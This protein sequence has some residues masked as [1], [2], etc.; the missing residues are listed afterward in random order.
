MNT[1]HSIH[2]VCEH[3]WT[4]N[5]IDIESKQNE[6]KSASDDEECAKRQQEEKREDVEGSQWRCR[7]EQKWV[8]ERGAGRES[9]I[10]KKMWI[11]CETSKQC[12]SIIQ[13]YYMKMRTI[14]SNGPFR[15]LQLWARKRAPHR[16]LCFNKITLNTINCHTYNARI[17][18]MTHSINIEGG[19]ATLRRRGKIRCD[20]SA[21]RIR[22]TKR[23]NFLL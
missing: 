23:V 8:A 7:G 5:H 17:H 1:R 6:N 12:V 4:T 2:T 16:Q 22:I 3:I 11:K 15:R 21:N 19:W 14:P 20:S 9:R 13:L 18:Y 10:V